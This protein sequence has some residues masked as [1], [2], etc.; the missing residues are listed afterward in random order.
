MA[1]NTK[2]VFMPQRPIYYCNDSTSRS[3]KYH[4]DQMMAIINRCNKNAGSNYVAPN[5]VIDFK[6]NGTQTSFGLGGVWSSGTVWFQNL[7]YD[8][9]E[10]ASAIAFSLNKFF[11]GKF[12]LKMGTLRVEWNELSWFDQYPV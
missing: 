3:L 5:H 10:I 11:A 1:A 9:A 6:I 4:L 2:V 12:Y 8:Y 7:D